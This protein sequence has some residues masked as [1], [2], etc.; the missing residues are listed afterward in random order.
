MKILFLLTIFLFV[1]TIGASAQ[2]CP[3]D[4][5]CI[6]PQAARKAVENAEAVKAQAEQIKTLQQAVQDEK[7][8]AGKL[9]IEFAEKAGETTALKQQAVRADAIITLLLKST[10]KRCAPFSILCL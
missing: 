10:H 4:K 2:E 1:L 8:V 3:S 5:V 7:D 9:K 6:T